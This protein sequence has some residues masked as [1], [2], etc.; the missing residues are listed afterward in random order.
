MIKDYNDFVAFQSSEANGY[1]TRDLVMIAERE[2]DFRRET[3]LVYLA[4]FVPSVL[5]MIFAFRKPTRLIVIL[6]ASACLAGLVM[7]GWY[8]LLALRR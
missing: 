8:C 5:L 2:A 4:F 7:L 6:L 3:W 1:K